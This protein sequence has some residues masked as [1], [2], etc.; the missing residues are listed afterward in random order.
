VV[1]VP[2][3]RGARVRSAR[4]TISRGKARVVRRRGRHVVLVA[5]RG[6]RAGV[7]VLRIRA[8]TSRGA[9]AQTRRLRTCA[10]RRG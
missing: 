9:V 8:V 2:R 10:Q 6:A 5:L 4:A 3:P 1:T 7:A